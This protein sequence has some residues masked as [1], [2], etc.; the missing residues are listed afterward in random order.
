MRCSVYKSVTIA[1]TGMFYESCSDLDELTDVTCSY[2]AF[3]KDMI[4][5][6]KR[7]TIY[8]INKPWVTKSVKSSTEHKRSV[9]KQ[10]DSSDLYL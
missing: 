9:F 5:P 10:S 3:C 7:V 8:P 2:V 4:I 6:C 1:Q